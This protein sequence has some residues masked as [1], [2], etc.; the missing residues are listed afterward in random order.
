MRQ[1]ADSSIL[2]AAEC[3]FDYAIHEHA[4][5]NNSHIPL[6]IHQTWRNLT[7][8]T[9]NDVIR[10]CVEAWLRT[11]TGA[12]AAEG[13]EMAY[14]LWD[15]EGIARLMEQYE[16]EL[17]PNFQLLP[18]PVEKADVFRVTVLKWF[19]G[20]YA[21]VDAKPLHHPY[22]WVHDSDLTPWTD[23]SSGVELT[24]HTPRMQTYAYPGY[25]PASYSSLIGPDDQL[26][27]R[28]PSVH[29]ILGIGAD[30]LPDPDPTYWRMGYTY[31][32]QTE[33]WAFCMAPH[34]PIASQFLTTLNETIVQE[35]GDLPAIDPLDIT[36]PPALTAAARTVAQREDPELS[37]D[38][39]SGRN[40]DPV[41][42]R[43]KIVAGDTLILPITGFSPGRGWFHNMGSQSVK[44]PNARLRHAAA[45]SWRKIDVKVHY[46]KFCRTAFGLCRG[47]KK[48][49]DQ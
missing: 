15:D 1:G 47:W 44:H 12:V 14:F 45:G 33:N 10:Q 37:W 3:A 22:G 17:L 36:G 21:D 23:A 42:G 34:H 30:N 13:P 16:P 46:G 25:V 32:I 18:Y 38:A 40:G 11:A 28:Q 6:I 49:P 24:L 39:L 29:A 4:F 7:P 48:I 5:L 35:R 43:G 27:L 19:G 31:P 26:A 8:Q 9:W 41:G 2:E 20:I